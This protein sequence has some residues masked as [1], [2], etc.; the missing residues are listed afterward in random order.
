MGFGE[1][2]DGGCQAAFRFPRNLHVTEKGGLA[3]PPKSRPTGRLSH[4]MVMK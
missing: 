3:V 4:E 2:R 1:L